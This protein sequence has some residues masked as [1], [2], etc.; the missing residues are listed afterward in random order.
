MEA[1]G[2]VSA[3]LQVIE[4][5]GSLIKKTTIFI[6]NAKEIDDTT[7]SLFDHIN[8][9]H[10]TAKSVQSVLRRW[11]ADIGDGRIDPEEDATLGQMR[12]AL[13]TTESA[14][15]RLEAKVVS[16]KCDKSGPAWMTRGRQALKLHIRTDAIESAQKQIEIGIVALTLMLL[17]TPRYAR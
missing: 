13:K 5:A 16:I 3:V 1:V 17:C 8:T 9:L 2:G 15:R 14:V 12:D 4:A 10:N 6:E 11:G 7:Q